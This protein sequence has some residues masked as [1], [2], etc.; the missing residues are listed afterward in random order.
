MTTTAVTGSA[1]DTRTH[2]PAATHLGFAQAVSEALKLNPGLKAAGH[3][4]IAATQ[5][6]SATARGRWGELDS[7]AA[8]SYWNDHLILVPMYQELLVNGISGLP[9]DRSQ[10]QYGL[11][12]QFPLYLGGKLNNQ[13]RIARLEAQKAQALL[14]GNRWQVRFN[15]VSLYS[16]AQA[17]DRAVAALEEEMA[18]MTQT[19]TN[20][21]EMVGLG[22]RPEVDRLKVVDELEGVR[23]QLAAAQADRVKVGA[24]LLAMLGR[25]PAGG[26]TVD[27]MADASP[28]PAPD[29]LPGLGRRVENNS[30]VRSARLAIEQADRGVKVARSD[31]MPKVYAGAS[32]QDYTGIGIGQS[33]DLWVATVSVKLP[34]F[35]GNARLK[36]LDAARQRQAAAREALTEAQ[37]KIQADL[38]EA[39]ARLDAV[40]T[41]LEAAKAQ[42]AAATEA[43]R[44]EHVRYDT[45]AGT[46]EDLLRARA[47]EARAKAGLASAQANLVT[48]GERINTIAEQEIVP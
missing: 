9:F 33:L 7:T 6:A 38:Q 8:Y 1:E 35:E 36:R 23:G 15:V 46:I 34:L 37:L 18:A 17:L 14:E 32:Y 5:E 44:I 12:Y 39:L 22:K 10:A 43:A 28:R 13:I 41:N 47:R 30:A 16:A 29:G 40:G 19:K 20:L 2:T 25:D 24:L 45:G 4:A 11:V 21:D 3:R 48:A 26:V 27:P 42:V 31:F